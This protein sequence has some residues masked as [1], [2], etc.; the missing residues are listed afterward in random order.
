MMGLGE[1][2]TVKAPRISRAIVALGHN[3]GMTVIAEGVETQEQRDFLAR[4]G[5]L[6]YQ[7][8][9]FSRPLPL[10]QF[11]AFVASTDHPTT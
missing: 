7:G 11:E 5:C 8:Y 9:L 2:V 10:A 1:A 6:S 4:E 3:L